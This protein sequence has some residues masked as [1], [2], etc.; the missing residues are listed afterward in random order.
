MDYKQKYL[1]YKQKYLNLK[2]NPLYKGNQ[3]HIIVQKEIEK[4]TRIAADSTDDKYDHS[5]CVNCPFNN[6]GANTKPNK[7]FPIRYNV[8]NCFYKGNDI[9]ANLLSRKRLNVDLFRKGKST[10][11]IENNLDITEPEGEVCFGNT[12]SS[13]LTFCIILEDNTKIS[14]HINPFANHLAE[15]DLYPEDD[16]IIL[17]KNEIINVFNAISE[18]KKTLLTINKRIK[19]VIVLGESKYKVYKNILTLNTFITQQNMK[20]FMIEN[21]FPGKDKYNIV[22]INILNF[23]KTEFNP[24]Y[25]DTTIFILK[26]NI[27]INGGQIYIVK[28]DGQGIIYN[29]DD[30]IID[31]F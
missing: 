11:T 14:V 12:I 22:P 24:F 3:D 10:F 6:S 26:Q 9:L 21:N 27:E 2:E 16:Q 8:D 4:C 19:K 13:C 25:T 5:K 15:G 17:K 7:C 28:S 29:K 1:K 23:L 31:Q 30:T 18:I 20:E